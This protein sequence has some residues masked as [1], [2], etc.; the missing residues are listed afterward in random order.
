MPEKPRILG[1]HTVA[2]TRLFHI[3][4]VDLRFA[5]G[6]EAQ[7]E[8][9]VGAPQ[10]AVLMV[11]MRDPQ[12]VLLTREYAGGMDRY[13]LA[14]PKGRIE[15][16]ESAEAAA[17]REMMEEIGFGAR[18]LRHVTSLTIAPG[19]LAHTTHV[20]LAQELYPAERA[21]D[22]PEPIEVLPWRLD[23]L[24]SLLAREDFTEARSIAALFMVRELLAHE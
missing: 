12:T 22:E 8:R 1:T 23:A 17:E 7:Y 3:E 9:I 10:G 13:E 24:D 4:A 16:G 19:Y 2:R 6:V 21:G 14:L 15:A 5:N 11:P 18:R 20:I